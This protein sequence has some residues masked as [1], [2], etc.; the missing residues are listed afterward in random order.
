LLQQI[1][2]DEAARSVLDDEILEA[3]DKVEQHSRLIPNEEAE[4]K[5]AQEL[6][7]RTKRKFLEDKPV[8]EQEIA[9]GQG[10]LAGEEKKL[11]DKELPR[12]FRETYDRLIRQVGGAN[13]L[14]CVVNQ[15]FCEG[16]NYQ[17]PVNSLA[18][19]TQGKPM[20]CS[21]CAR[22]LFLPED[23]VFDKG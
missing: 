9:R 10:L 12:E 3:M 14:A 23:F 7:E 21:S 1:K 22:L 16:C 2:A 11:E 15:K 20:T 13:A 17:V 4:V 19:L 5:K 18:L 6:Y 8:I